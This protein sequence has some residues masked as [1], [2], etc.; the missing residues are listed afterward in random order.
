MRVL[1]IPVVILLCAIGARA[2][3]ASS[4][5]DLLGRYAQA[6]NDTARTHLLSLIS[7]NLI[8]SDPDSAL[9]TG[10]QAL[11]IAQGLDDP[12]ALGD[13]HNSLGWLAVVQGRTDSAEAHLQKALSIFERIGDPAKT[14]K[15]LVNMGW[16]AQKQGMDVL[17]LKYFIRAL[18]DAETAQD[19]VSLAAIDFSLG[20][21]Y[22]NAGDHQ[23]AL[24]HFERSM[25]TEQALGRRAKVGNCLTSIAN[26]QIVTGDTAS[27]LRNYDQAAELFNAINDPAGAGLVEENIGGLYISTS[28]AKALIHLT[29]ALAHYERSGNRADKAYVLRIIGI[30]QIELGELDKAA[31]SLA[32]GQ[33]LA[34][35]TG[36]TALVMNYE[37]SFAELAGARADVEGVFSHLHRYMALKDSLQGA[38]TQHELARLRT[39]FETERKEKDNAVLRAENSAQQQRLHRRGIQLYGSIAMALLAL[40]SAGLFR[41]NFRQKRK[42]AQVL[43]KLNAELEQSHAEISEINGLLEMKLLRS[44]MNPHFIYNGLNSAA[45]LT[46]AGHQEEALA[47]L[48]GFSRLLRTVLDHS[49]KDRVG[50]EEELDF[51]QR[52]L[53]IEAQRL[54]G[55]SYSVE[56]ESGL[57]DDDVELPALL[58]QP[59]VENAVWHGLT[60]KVGERSVQV[61]FSR[62]DAGIACV[63]TDSGVGRVVPGP[64]KDAK[65]HSLGMQLTGERLRLLTRRLGDESAVIVEDLKDAAGVAT[66]TRVTLHLPEQA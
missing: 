26:L 16:L 19:S 49:V 44:Q 59:F 14:S 2:Q 62:S 28:P 56:A 66:G 53:K 31:G 22:R 37:R 43:E 50:L 13:A 27:A 38:D 57:I 64:E 54:P 35:E 7:F 4:L 17:A 61:R 55:L 48:Q 52:Y 24:E 63:I 15:T 32:E 3:D 20:V 11:G 46:Q 5:P 10:Q 65:H 33:A 45:R 1:S 42:H 36:A 21:V 51:L 47:Y 58:V 25:R 30:A 9:L 8:H 29:K 60:N 34:L 40:V 6:Q 18:H 39:E 12:N 23:Q 41:R